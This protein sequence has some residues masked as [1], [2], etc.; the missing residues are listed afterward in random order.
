LAGQIII[1]GA[2]MLRKYAVVSVLFFAV[3]GFSGVAWSSVV[4]TWDAYGT[5]TVKVSVKG[6]GSHTEK[7]NFEDDFIFHAN[8]YFEIIDFA[9]AW[10]QKGKKFTVL[11]DADEIGDYFSDNLSDEVGTD[12]Y[13][14]V[15]KAAFSGQEQRNGTIKGSFTMNM[16][17]YV[18]DEDCECE[19]KGTLKVSGKFTGSR[20]AQAL[21]LDEKDS[22]ESRDSIFDMTVRETENIIGLMD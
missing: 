4:G 15:T 16:K 11:L 7:V 10:S 5:M 12:V 17:L 3:I 22:I 8:N 18:Y 6:Y 9:G 1:E 14:E 21:T 19:R 20:S 13:V 2:I